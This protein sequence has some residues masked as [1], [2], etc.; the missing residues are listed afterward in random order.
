MRL[1]NG[2][3]VLLIFSMN[4]LLNVPC[5]K[6][7]SLTSNL[8]KELFGY[9]FL[10]IAIPFVLVFGISAGSTIFFMMFIGIGIYWVG[11]KPSKK[12]VC[13]VCSQKNRKTA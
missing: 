10:I 4:S 2:K 11:T 12:V 8:N 1:N 13:D 3:D 5:I 7:R 6:C 9:F